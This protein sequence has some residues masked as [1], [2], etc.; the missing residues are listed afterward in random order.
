MD[1]KPLEGIFAKC[2][3]DVLK[4]FPKHIEHFLKI[5][6]SRFCKT[7]WRRLRTTSWKGLKDVFKMSSRWF[8]KTFW[9]RLRKMSRRSL[10]KNVLKTSWRHMTRTNIL[11][12]DA[13][14]TSSEYVW[15]RWTCLSWS[16]SLE[17]I[18]WRQRWKTFSRR[19]H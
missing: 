7:S 3:E 13:L 10:V 2:I 1:W 18:L 11:V 15:V 14:K 5:S 17:D 8:C 4:T 9:I 6:S 19:L 12:L 16:R